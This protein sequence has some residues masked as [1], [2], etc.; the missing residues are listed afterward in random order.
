MGLLEISSLEELHIYLYHAL[1]LEHATIPPYLTALY[2]LKPGSNSQPLHVM[3]VVAVEEMLHLTLVANVLNAVGGSPDLTRDDFVPNYPSA[4]PNGELDFEVGLQRF[5]RDQVQTFLNIER[6]PAA[7]TPGHRVQRRAANGKQP[8]LQVTADPEL[9]FYSIGEFYAEIA[10]GLKLLA[11]EARESGKTLFVGD[12]SRQITPEYYFSGGGEIVPVYDLESALRAIEL[13]ATQGEGLGGGIFDAEN[14]L[15]HYHAFEQ[16]ILGRYYDPGDKAAEPSGVEIAIDWDAVYP[17]RP[18]AKLADYPKGSD[19]RAAAI[20]FNAAYKDFLTLLTTAF[21][22]QPALLI[23][24]VGS[25]FRLKEL[26]GQL[27]RNPI[28]GSAGEHAAPTFELA[29]QADP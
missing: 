7:P 12:K 20:A 15:A 5:C 10:R 27:M 16:T 23:D 8:L 17:I 6:P 24:A 22:G 13:I 14:E 2:S 29:L 3:R 28:P 19:I 26:V 21:N 18:N 1:Q 4:L 11:L 9:H 25:M